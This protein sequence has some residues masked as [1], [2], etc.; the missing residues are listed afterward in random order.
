MVAAGSHWLDAGCG[1]GILTRELTRLGATGDAVDASPAMI[2]AA[3]ESA[4]GT[5]LSAAFHFRRVETLEHLDVDDGEYDGVLC[6]SVIE[7]VD[8]PADAL[9]EVARVL[10][11]G[12][13]LL[14]SVAN[15]YSTVRNAQQL[16]RSAGLKHRFKYLEVSRASFS[17]REI[18]NALQVCGVQVDDV[19]G[20]D[21]VLPTWATTFLP[22][23]L[24]FVSGTKR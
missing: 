7:Y 18:R 2:R 9:R 5:S 1:S 21:P 10:K 16:A 8:S 22:P 20:F 23:A 12:G 19:R 24:I 14:L 13:H 17:R 15:R 6:S 11:P 4:G 3:T